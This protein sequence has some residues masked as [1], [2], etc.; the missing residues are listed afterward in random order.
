MT[1]FSLTAFCD[2]NALSPDQVWFNVPDAAGKNRLMVFGFSRSE[3]LKSDSG[4][5][6]F[7]GTR[8][9]LARC[10]FAGNFAG[11]LLGPY[12][13]VHRLDCMN[14]V[15]EAWDTSSDGPRTLR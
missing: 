1:G 12:V 9:N 13:R 8:S 11:F 5:H 10:G 7:L 2:V 15:V 14:R 6:I 4:L 3:S